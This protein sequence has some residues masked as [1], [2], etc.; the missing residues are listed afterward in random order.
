MSISSMVCLRLCDTVSMWHARARRR[1]RQMSDILKRQD[2]GGIATLT[3]DDDATL[4]SLSDAMLADLGDQLSDISGSDLKAVVI[5]AEGRAFCAGHN[6]RQMQD[7]RQAEDGGAAAFADLFDRCTAVM[8]AIRDLPQPVIAEV[9][10]L[11]TA[12]GCQL[13]AACD[14]AVASGN[15]RFGV[16][17][18]NIGL[19][20][21]TPMVALSRNLGR[22]RAF[23]MLSTGRFLT[24]SEAEAA[25]LVNRVVDPEQLRDTTRE[26][27]ETVAGK[28]SAAVRI[29]KGAFYAQ[30]ELGLDDAY[31]LT[32]DAMVANL[33]EPDTAEGMAAFLEK[34]KP[35]WT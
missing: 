17:G 35:N 15:A 25:G 10:S 6:L 28:L 19:F 4:N 3:L 26:L 9:H 13:V 5:R 1:D 8:T 14:M 29:G 20:C 33:G 7:M 24:A 18:V 11:A 31:A 27:A 30:A 34:R 12:A 16:N 23:E 2:A 32:R 21:S 22:K